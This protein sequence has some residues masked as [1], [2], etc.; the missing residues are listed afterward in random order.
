MRD[1]QL[2]GRSPVLATG[3]MCATSHPLGAKAAID[4][5]EAYI[6]QGGTE[7]EDAVL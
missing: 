5:L 7:W 1:F 2:P 3:G 6:L 4:V